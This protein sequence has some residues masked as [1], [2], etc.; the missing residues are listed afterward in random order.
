MF[1][2]TSRGRIVVELSEIVEHHST[3]EHKIILIQTSHY[4]RAEVELLTDQLG[5]TAPKKL[6]Y[7]IEARISSDQLDGV[8]NS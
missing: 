8:I 2:S 7:V 1:E 5:S 4:R 6:L 3:V